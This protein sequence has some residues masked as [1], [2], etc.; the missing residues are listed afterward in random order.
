MKKE[1]RNLSINDIS[2]SQYN[3]LNRKQLTANRN[4][5]S[6][7]QNINSINFLNTDDNI[8]KTIKFHSKHIFKDIYSISIAIDFTNKSI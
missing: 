6:N 5:S 7:N 2:N 3:D 8:L 1:E 4:N